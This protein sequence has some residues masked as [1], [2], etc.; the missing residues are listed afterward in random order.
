MVVVARS[1]WR[2][3]APVAPALRVDAFASDRALDELDDHRPVAV[4][5]VLPRPMAGSVDH[6]EL[7]DAFGQG[8]DNLFGGGDRC[9]GV[10]LADR[11]EGR[12][13]DAAEL[14]D[15]VE[16]ADELHPGR[17]QL[18]ILARA[19]PL[20]FVWDAWAEG[21]RDTTPLLV[22]HRLATEA[23]PCDL[24]NLVARD[25]AEALD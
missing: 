3:R 1:E 24:R 11:D 12:R 9:D 19:S 6:L 15:D 25:A 17:I 16:S 4:R 18:E 20:L 21:G 10:E 22:G 8:A 7:P 5:S 23:A 13:V 14:I 2:L